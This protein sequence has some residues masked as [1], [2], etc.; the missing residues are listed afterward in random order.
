MDP[1]TTALGS[2]RPR[3][4]RRIFRAVQTPSPRM[5]LARVRERGLRLG[6]GVLLRR[7]GP[8]TRCNVCVGSGA[9]HGSRAGATLACAMSTSSCPSPAS[10]LTRRRSTSRS[11]LNDSATRRGARPQPEARFLYDGVYLEKL[12][13]RGGVGSMLRCIASRSANSVGRGSTSPALR[14]RFSHALC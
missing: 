8:A 3:Q 6:R 10:R 14:R 9:R 13:A 2:A 7:P 4:A 12:G 1:E 11:R 5:T